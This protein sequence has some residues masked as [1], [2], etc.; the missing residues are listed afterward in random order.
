M[1]TL[2][3]IRKGEAMKLQRVVFVIVGVTCLLAGQASAQQVKTD[4]ERGVNFGQYKTFSWEHVKTQDPLLVDRIKDSVNATLAAKGWTKADSG[5]DISIVAVEITRDQQTL[6]TFYDGLGGHWSW[7]G[8]GETTTT[9]ETYEV[10]TL[11]V[12]LFD[13]KTKKL[14]WRGAAS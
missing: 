9:T 13:A 7:G 8:F 5:G 1:A 10:G 2:L 12:D 3:H 14:V 4:Y 11:I 6:K